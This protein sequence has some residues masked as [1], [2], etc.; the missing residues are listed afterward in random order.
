MIVQKKKKRYPTLE[1]EMA[2]KDVIRSDIAKLLH[3][4]N[5]VITSRMNG[6]SD[7]VFWELL[8]IQQYLETDLTIDELFAEEVCE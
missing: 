4:T 3:R 7:W 5:G 2:R 8:A 6:T 1:A